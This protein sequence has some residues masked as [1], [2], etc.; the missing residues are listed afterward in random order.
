MRALLS[1][2]GHYA[3]AVL[4]GY[5]YSKV[6]F[7][8]SNAPKDKVMILFAPVIVHTIFDWLLFSISITISQRDIRKRAYTSTS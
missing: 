4:M 5:Y 1:V 7:G 8:I 6:H 2:P 3:F